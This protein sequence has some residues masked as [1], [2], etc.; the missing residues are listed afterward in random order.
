MSSVPPEPVS[1]RKARLPWPRVAV[2]VAACSLGAW[3]WLTGGVVRGG[4]VCRDCH[5][6]R[7]YTAISFSF[8][9]SG[10]RVGT[11]DVDPGTEFGRWLFPPESEPHR[12]SSMGSSFRGLL[13]RG[14]S[15]GGPLWDDL[16]W[17]LAS[18]EAGAD[19][20]ARIERGEF[21]AAFVRRAIRESIDAGVV[22]DEGDEI[23]RRIGRE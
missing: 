4:E 19:L 15:C 17:R 22:S 21:E 23:L 14:T 12:W 13:A 1:A 2:A 18:P 9:D 11:D 16:S 3:L 6:I 8:P 20:R 10:W 5:A 7:R